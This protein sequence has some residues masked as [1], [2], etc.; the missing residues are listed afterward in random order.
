MAG[1]KVTIGA[2]SRKASRE[3]RTFE[4][5]TKGIASS[6]AKGFKERIGHKL[7]DGL[8]VAVR[9]IP[10]MI[11]TAVTTASDLNEE[12]S[13][14]EVIFGSAASDIRNFAQTAI[15]SMG[16]SELA[17]MGAT[18]QFGTLF[19]TMGM[20]QQ[21]AADMSKEMTK[22]AADL[23]SFHN[24][25]T[26]DAIGAIGAA[27][28]GESE[29]IRRYG[30]LLNEATLKAEALAKGIYDGK[31]ALDP[32]TKALASY[33]L[34]LK[35]TTDAQGDFSRTSQGLAGQKKILA[36]RFEELTI[37]VGQAFLPV[38]EDAI[39]ALNEI[40]LDSAVDFIDIL[41]VGFSELGDVVS[42]T[43]DKLKVFQDFI[44]NFGIGGKLGE[45]IREAFSSIPKD[46]PELGYT[47]DFLKDEKPPELSE[48][49]K[50]ERDFILE[51]EKKWAAGKENLKL[52]K[53][54]AE[55]MKEHDQMAKAAYYAELE[56]K[57][58]LEKQREEKEAILAIEKE[59]EKIDKTMDQV[60]DIQSSLNAAMS[61]SS[62][63]AVSSM[64]SIGSGGG[65]MGDLNLQKTQTDLQR[66]L[67]SQ[68]EQMVILLEAVKTGVSQE[69]ISH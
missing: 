60:S 67:V 42:D 22:L 50:A 55:M 51:Q 52:K 64:Q 54:E 26:E 34:I 16:L 14:S 24:T 3:L 38:F 11:N 37:A 45:A 36:A 68:Q 62:I 43:W 19:K 57:E 12:V 39:T 9:D 58:L 5:K 48:G 4:K 10:Q 13:K 1:V 32:A 41:K 20:G 59:Q 7:L 33:S 30:V 28:R 35:Q 29:P 8:K 63:T 18:G 66:Q 46:I 61:R 56:R 47:P 6:I 25:T 15:E 2:D 53:E 69:P 21:Q 65:V 23:G 27:L 49:E 40:D 17:A 31:G 44:K